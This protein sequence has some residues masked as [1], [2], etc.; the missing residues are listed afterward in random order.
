M[1]AFAQSKGSYDS[2]GEVELEFKLL[3]LGEANNNIV[4]KGRDEPNKDPFLETPKEGR[5]WMDK[6]AFLGDILSGLGGLYDGIFKALRV[7]GIIVSVAVLA[8]I[9]SVLASAFKG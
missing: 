8:Y 6:L 1:S 5:S 9:V 2:G 3:T 7:F 4:G